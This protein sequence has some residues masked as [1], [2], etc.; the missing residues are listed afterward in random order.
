MALSNYGPQTKTYHLFLQ[1]KFYRNTAIYNVLLS[2]AELRQRS[3]SLQNW[4]YYL[5][6]YKKWLPNLGLNIKWSYLILRK[7][8]Q[9]YT[10]KSLS[11][12]WLFATPW[13]IQSMEFQ[14]RIL[15]WVAF[16]FSRGSSQ[17]RDWTW[18]S[19]I[20]DRFFTS[21]A[22][23]EAQIYTRYIDSSVHIF[24]WFCIKIPTE[25]L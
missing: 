8:S 16:P 10:W 12:V 4:K 5:A 21:W 17:P 18:V 1:I 15:E 20:A 11:H 19:C 25:V 6:L 2:T 3:Y 7:V 22:T 23:R 9:I 24:T 13:T 14:A